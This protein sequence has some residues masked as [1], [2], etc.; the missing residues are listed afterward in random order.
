MLHK[1]KSWIKRQLLLGALW[2]LA[3]ASFLLPYSKLQAKESNFKE[4][5][6]NQIIVGINS[7]DLAFAISARFAIA[8][9]NAAAGKEL[10]VEDNNMVPD[11]ILSTIDLP[12]PILGVAIPTGNHCYLGI[13]P[14]QKDN[15]N[16]FVHELG[17]CLGFGHNEEN[18]TSIMAPYDGENNWMT[19]E[20]VDTLRE[21]INRPVL[22]SPSP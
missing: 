15:A 8:T 12:D 9:W 7:N 2:L 1:L 3:V 20:I 14:D 13:R 22:A 5:L 16:V 21:V 19:Q 4:Y 11:F 18:D 17:H 6:P 10:L